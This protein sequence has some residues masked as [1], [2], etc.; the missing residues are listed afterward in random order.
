MKFKDKLL[1]ERNLNPDS[2]PPA[3]RARLEADPELTAL[4]EEGTALTGIHAS[5][6]A[7]PPWEN[8]RSQVIARAAAPKESAMRTMFNLSRWYV[9]LALAT[10]A[11]AVISGTYMLL[12]PSGPRAWA[13][14][15]GYVLT[16]DLPVADYVAG[17][18]CRCDSWAECDHKYAGNFGRLIE[19][20]AADHGEEI[21]M[22]PHWD[23]P[24]SRLK[25]FLKTTYCEPS[26]GETGETYY[27][28][29]VTLAGFSPEELDSLLTEISKDPILPEPLVGDATWYHVGELRGDFAYSFTVGG[30]LFC[31]PEYATAEEIEQELNNWVEQTYGT[32]G[33][34]EV[35]IERSITGG[36]TITVDLNDCVPK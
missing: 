5:F 9:R 31:F 22:P 10:L 14:T 18:D 2:L 23:A 32:P 15:N 16:F 21:G 27:K 12:V 7:A 17:Q 30:E 4:A 28:L 3:Q 8:L 6:P 33:R 34:I 20:W 29:D 19:A 36:K 11:I 35:T 24:G 1:L 13:T 25:Y 26:E